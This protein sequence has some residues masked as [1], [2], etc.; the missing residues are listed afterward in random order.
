LTIIITAFDLRCCQDAIEAVYKSINRLPKYVV[1]A[2]IEKC[3]DKIA[4][5]PLLKKLETFLLL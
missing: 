3:F 5:K 1:D 2:D 4:H